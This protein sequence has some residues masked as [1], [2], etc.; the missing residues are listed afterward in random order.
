VLVEM[1]K[2]KT[3]VRARQRSPGARV[4]EGAGFWRMLSD[5]RTIAFAKIVVT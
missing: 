5:E 3:M 1:H 4:S 2:V